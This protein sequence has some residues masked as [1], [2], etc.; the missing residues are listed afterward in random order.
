[1][2]HRIKL[3]AQFNQRRKRQADVPTSPENL[4][5]LGEPHSLSVAKRAFRLNSNPALPWR[6]FTDKP[7]FLEVATERVLNGGS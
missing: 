6:H 1:V 2:Q 3:V 4:D 7:T 5:H